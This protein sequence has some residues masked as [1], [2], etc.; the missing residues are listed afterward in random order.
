M[1]GEIEVGVG[2]KDDEGDCE[3]KA[4]YLEARGHCKAR[5]EGYI[6]E[7][8]EIDDEKCNRPINLKL[9]NVMF[10]LTSHPCKNNFNLRFNELVGT[11]NGKFRR[12]FG[13]REV[14]RGGGRKETEEEVDDW[15]RHKPLADIER[16]Q[17]EPIN[18]ILTRV[19]VILYLLFS[20]C[21]RWLASL[22]RRTPSKSLSLYHFSHLFVFANVRP[23]DHAYIIYHPFTPQP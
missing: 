8:Q 23:L 15:A 9:R 14:A 4:G 3:G 19:E 5:A 16:G 20:L 12:V 21:V 13:K 17:I 6:Q 18:Q 7:R 10:V 1:R 11:A 2:K 22:L